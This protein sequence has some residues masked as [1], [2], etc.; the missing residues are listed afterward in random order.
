MT[1]DEM[2][3]D[4]FETM[5]GRLKAAAL[6][7][8][9]KALIGFEIGAQA[10]TLEVEGGSCRT[11]PALA[12]D[13]DAVVQTGPEEWIDVAS[14]AVDPTA[15]FLAGKLRVE[16]DI[17]KLLAAFGLF[18]SYTSDQLEVKNSSWVVETLGDFFSVREDGR[19]MIEEL[20]CVQL[21]EDFGTPVF[22]T[23]EGQLRQNYRLIKE[24]LVAAYPENEVNVMWAIKSNTSLALRKILNE[25]GAG[26]DQV[27]ELTPDRDP[28]DYVLLGPDR[29]LAAGSYRAILKYRGVGG[30]S[31][32]GRFE[33]ALSNSPEPLA[34]A[35]IPPALPGTGDW[36]RLA[37]PFSLS[38]TAPVRF[39]VFYSGSG[40]LLLDRI[41]IEGEATP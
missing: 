7:P 37:L 33:V 41:A 6:D 3:R 2:V 17:E 30:S 24:A 8:D 31:P 29:L 16:G 12:K 32:P 26:G 14:N 21:A 25:E 13:C 9:F 19:F 36:R 40:T 10:W 23:S 22:V 4:S 20:D 28:G 39:R 34:L 18:E 1:L 35:E 15:L 11:E 38:R 5:P 27:V